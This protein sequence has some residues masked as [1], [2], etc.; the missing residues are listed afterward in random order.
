[1]HFQQ[2]K[3]KQNQIGS[4]R[5]ID[6][7]AMLTSTGSSIRFGCL[8]GLEKSFTPGCLFL[9]QIKQTNSKTLYPHSTRRRFRCAHGDHGASSNR[10]RSADISQFLEPL[11]FYNDS[12]TLL[13]RCCCDGH[14]HATLLLCFRG[15]LCL[16]KALLLRFRYNKGDQATLSLR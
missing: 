3:Q 8:N 4:F 14:A 1:M 2:P 10:R 7:R 6:L 5:S 9:Q 16:F 13:L 12:S 11:H 15:A